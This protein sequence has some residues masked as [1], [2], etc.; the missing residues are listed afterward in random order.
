M[1]ARDMHFAARTWPEVLAAAARRNLPAD[2]LD[3]FRAWL[4]GGRADPKRLD[5]IALLE[6]IR[7]GR[8]HSGGN[9]V[10]SFEFRPTQAF[11][12]LHRGAT[13]V[14]RRAAIGE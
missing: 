10:R 8:Q 2:E 14:D 13:S 4:P 11:S 7:D 1:I 6:A 3:S 12:A 5:A 9:A